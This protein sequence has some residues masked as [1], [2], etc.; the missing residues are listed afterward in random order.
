MSLV[1]IVFVPVS[2]GLLV[3]TLFH[4]QTAKLE[5]VLPLVSM[6]AIV[7][8]I[9]TVVALN[10]SQ[11]VSIGPIVALAVVLHNGAGL[12]LGYTACRMIGF[13]EKVCRTV[14]FEVGL[15]NS[16]LLRHWR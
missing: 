16:A 8:I 13:E 11:I 6:V 4:K 14:A 5:P 1:K 3:N 2:I 7:I 10:A 15:Q 9:A 12:F